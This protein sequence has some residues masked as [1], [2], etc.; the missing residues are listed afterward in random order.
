MKQV[1]IA[2][3]GL[4]TV[5]AG[6]YRIL[7]NNR[8]EILRNHGLDVVVKRILDKREERF[9]ELNVPQGVGTT[10]LED[11][12]ND[13]SISVVVEVMGGVE[14]ALSFILRALKAG[15][16]VISANKELIAKHWSEIESVA[17]EN[18][19]GFYHEG[20]CVGGVP[21]IRVLN[22]S[23]QG[24]KILAVKG[25]INGTTNFILTKMQDEGMPYDDALAMAVKLGY[26]EI[27][28]MDDVEGFDAMYKLSILSSLAF[29]T[30]IPYQEI[31]REGITDVTGKELAYAKSMGYTVKLLAVGQKN[32]EGIEV[33]IHPTCVKNTHPIAA[34]SEENNAVFITG[35]SVGH[36]MLRGKGA[37]AL[38]TGSAIVSDIV[39]C[40]KRNEPLYSPFDNT[41]KLDPDV[42]LVRDFCTNWFVVLSV[43]GANMDSLLK[44]FIDEDNI[45]KEYHYSHKTEELVVVTEKIKES[46]LKQVL[47]QASNIASVLM[48]R[49]AVC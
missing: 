21:V 44:T 41:G 38:P 36:L 18:G 31:A 2:I 43:K 4:G 6:A 33:R 35:D 39:Y 22:E 20:S 11:V 3:M 49:K 19:V 46:A 26:A 27:D 28:P 15:K 37:G 17:K 16:N 34:V 24:D 10:C 25:I 42:T 48:K 23:I 40:A 12:L 7:V 32:E 30:C 29:K 5:G 13:E 1:N 9:A 8:D 14:P 47:E 45:I